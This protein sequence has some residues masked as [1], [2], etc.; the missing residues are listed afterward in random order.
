M[1]R[2]VSKIRTRESDTE[3]LPVYVRAEITPEAQA[4][5]TDLEARNYA[6][7]MRELDA[8]LTRAGFPM[9]TTEHTKHTEGLMA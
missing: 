5:T 2:E 9:L 1:I 7:W 3:I 6:R 4:R 8:L